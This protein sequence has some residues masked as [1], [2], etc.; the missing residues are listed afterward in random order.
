M[1]K[2]IRGA[3]TLPVALRLEKKPT[4]SAEE[5]PSRPITLVVLVGRRRPQRTPVPDSVEHMWQTLGNSP[6]HY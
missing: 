6:L 4:A 5:V 1:P 2:V 3:T